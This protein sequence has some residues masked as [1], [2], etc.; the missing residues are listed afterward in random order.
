V[1]LPTARGPRYDLLRGGLAADELEASPEQP[2]LLLERPSCITNLEVDAGLRIRLS[3]E[4]GQPVDR[5]VVHVD[6]YDPAGKWIRYYSGNA[7]VVD[8]KAEFSIPF[9]LNDMPGQWRLKVRDVISGLEATRE[10]P[11][12]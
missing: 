4:H 1:K 11:A 12:P 5:S 7:D 2:V 3:D 6:V 9:A 8:G 10:V